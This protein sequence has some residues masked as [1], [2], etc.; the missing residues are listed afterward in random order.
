LLLGEFKI[1]WYLV[2]ALYLEP[3]ASRRCVGLFNYL[4][5]Y[6]TR[7]LIQEIEA[8]K[9]MLKTLDYYSTTLLVHVIGFWPQHSILSRE[10]V[11]RS[12]SLFNYLALYITC[13][14]IQ[15]IEAHKVIL[16]TLDYSYSTPLV[17]LQDGRL[18][19]YQS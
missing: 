5:L 6:I 4:A 11:V 18:R 2:T 15:E 13:S 10:S 7:S 17:V 19:T 9:V 16:K 3:C 1:C 8:H 14:L 12:V